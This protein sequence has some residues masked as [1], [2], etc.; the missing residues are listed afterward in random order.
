MK[1]CEERV[2]ATLGVN[3]QFLSHEQVCIYIT[4]F[5]HKWCTLIG[6]ESEARVVYQNEATS[7]YS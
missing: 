6:Q 4:R 7:V 3:L 2:N 5:I 1:V